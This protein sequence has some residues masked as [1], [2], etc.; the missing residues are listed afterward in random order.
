MSEAEW[1][2]MHTGFDAA[3]VRRGVTTGIARPP[4]G[5]KFVYGFNSVVNTSG[6]VALYANQA[7]FAPINAR[8]GSVRGAVQRGASGGPLNFAPFLF[9]GANGLDVTSAHAYLLGLD[10]DDPHRIVLRKGLI[11]DGLPSTSVG[12][13]GILAAGT[14]SFVNSTWVHL[15]LDAIVNTNGDV[16][17]QAYRSDLALHPV[18]NPAWALVPG[19]GQFIDDALGINSGSP[20]LQGGYIGFGFQSKDV[21]RR[22]FFD[23][24]EV[25]RQL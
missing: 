20:P 18:D 3:S 6:A 8:G 1:T 14:E 15:R 17:L 9:L 19:I 25:Q 12:T 2:F 24:I 10:D 13:N 22:A 7:S 4:N 11:T 21:S 16:L 5:G 23:Q